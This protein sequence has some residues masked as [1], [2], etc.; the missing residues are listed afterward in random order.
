MTMTAAGP[1][2]SLAEL[3]REHQAGVWRYLRA[4]GADPANADDLTQDTFLAVHEKPFEQRTRIETAAYLR[5]VARNLF[6]KSRRNA[7]K[8][9]SAVEIERVDERW[10]ELVHD[11]GAELQRALQQCLGELDDKPKQALDM[12]YKYGM[13]RVEIAKA[14]SMTD[15]GVKT[16]LART[17]ARLRKCMELRLQG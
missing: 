6:L 7:G 10:N 4:L 11:D 15:D 5:I 12:Q 17:K 1:T 8:E 3:M 16:L 14:M 2:L 9:I 13:Q